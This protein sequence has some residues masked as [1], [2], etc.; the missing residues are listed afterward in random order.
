MDVES[1]DSATQAER[2]NIEMQQRANLSIEYVDDYCVVALNA[3][4][5]LNALSCE[6]VSEL[7][8][9]VELL[10]YNSKIRAVILTGT[11]KA[12]AAGADIK[13][14]S[15]MTP[16]QAQPFARKT[17]RIYDQI[18]ASQKIYIAAINGYA[19]GGGM[20][21]ALACDLRIAAATAKLGLPECGLGIIPGGGGTQRLPRLIGEG[22]AKELIFTGESIDAETALRYGVVNQVVQPE[23]LLD[24]ATDLARRIMG[25]GS[26]AIVYAK[27]AIHTGGQL[28]MVSAV[29]HENTLFGLCFAT[30]DQREGMRAFL[31]KRS[32]VFSGK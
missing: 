21:L 6:M 26:Q 10:E 2:W 29:A 11:G 4:K 23:N 16:W 15:T 25:K 20:E 18:E 12:F 28:D 17:T 9:C 14:M 24:A 1:E 19:L 5:T 3:P 31:E 8:V 7:G 22:R 13:G 27:A 32:P 30:E